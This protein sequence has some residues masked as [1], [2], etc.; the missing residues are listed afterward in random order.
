MGGYL[1]LYISTIR[2][3]IATINAQNRRRVSQVTY[4]Y[5]TSLFA[6]H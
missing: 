5:I 2:P 6:E 3:M 1:F 4:M